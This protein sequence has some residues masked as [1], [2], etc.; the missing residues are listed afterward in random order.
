MTVLWGNSYVKGVIALATSIVDVGSLFRLTVQIPRSD[1]ENPVKGIKPSNLAQ[2]YS[3]E[4]IQNVLIVDD[5]GKGD[6]LFGLSLS[7]ELRKSLC[8]KSVVKFATFI[9][10]W[11]YWC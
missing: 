7:Q 1:L 8:H 9:S 10:N 4:G 6:C 5:T 3:H 11:L 2:L